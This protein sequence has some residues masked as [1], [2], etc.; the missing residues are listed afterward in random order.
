MRALPIDTVATGTPA[1][2]W[3]IDS[4]ES[5]PSRCLSA[6]GTPITGNG[7]T[8]ASMPGRWAAPP[9]PA[10]MTS[11]PRACASRP[12]ASISSGM[13]CAETTS[14]SYAMPNSPSAVAAASIVG[15]SESEPITMPTRGES[16][17]GHS[18]CE[19]CCRAAGPG[20]HVVEI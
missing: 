4:S 9:A 13:R 14:A 15:Q 6:T 20:E 19:Q 1:G 18:V 16:V 17:M 7:V 5:M 8:A 10:M 11:M 12:Y 2:I 3:T